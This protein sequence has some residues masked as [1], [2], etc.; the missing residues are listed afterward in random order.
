M[1]ISRRGFIGG[2][3]TT[4]ATLGGIQLGFSNI[5]T[6]TMVSGRTIVYLFLRGGIDGLNLIVPRTGIN[7][8]EYESKR[9]NIQVPLE[10]ILNLN[11]DFGL[12]GSAAGLKALY[13]QGT[14]AVVQAVGMP[15][16]GIIRGRAR[17]HVIR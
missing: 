5:S 12:H 13:D 17:L 3:A 9:A 15:E 10:N 16:L 7:R 11:D 2:A 8:T 1:K 4:A 14:L 6:R